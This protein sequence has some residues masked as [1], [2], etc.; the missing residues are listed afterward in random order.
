MVVW[1]HN[2]VEDRVGFNSAPV[3]KAS[4]IK[5]WFAQLVVE[6]LD[7]LAPSPDLNNIPPYT[8]VGPH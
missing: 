5:K 8:K 4:S 2:L 6:E 3:H 1:E 7:W